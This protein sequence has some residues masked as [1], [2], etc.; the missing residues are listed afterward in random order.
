LGTAVN[1]ILPTTAILQLDAEH[2]VGILN[3]ISAILLCVLTLWIL[4]RE[5]P[6]GFLTQLSP[7][8]EPHSH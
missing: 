2:D 1:S 8:A 6:R 4:I 3:V 7:G 5:G